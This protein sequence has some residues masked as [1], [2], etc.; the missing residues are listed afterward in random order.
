[1]T[2]NKKDLETK[3]FNQEELAEAIDEQ[4]VQI[5]RENFRLKIKEVNNYFAKTKVFNFTKS[6]V[7]PILLPFFIVMSF[8]VILP[9]ILIVVYAFVQPSDGIKMFEIS[10]NKFIRLFTDN[11]LMISLLLSIGYAIVAGMLCVVLGYPIALIM[12][13]MRSKILARNMWVIVTL[14]M[15]ISMLLKV[16]G[17]RSLFYLLASSAIGTPIAMIIGMTYMFI[18]FAIA[19]IYDSLESRRIDLEEAAQDL[20]CS[21]F[22]TFWTVTLRSSM[23]GVLTAFSLVLVQAATSLIVVHYMGDGKINLITA[24]IESYFFQGSDFGFGAA[25]SVVL[26]II[27]FIVMLVM[28]LLSNKFESKEGKKKWKNS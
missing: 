13:K 27:V 5:K 19:P 17:L 12:A 6:T 11:D 26:A 24:A 8:L 10:I 7:W 9:L 16:L 1:M 23:P 4:K 2:K 20:G 28:K 22:K 14:P 21:N 18:P 15:W 25:I 3:G